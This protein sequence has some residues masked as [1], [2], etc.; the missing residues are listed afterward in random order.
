VSLVSA[1][2]AL[3]RPVAVDRIV[4]IEAKAVPILTTADQEL[5]KTREKFRAAAK[6]I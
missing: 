4:F 6:D 5:D 1:L 2:Q 3:F